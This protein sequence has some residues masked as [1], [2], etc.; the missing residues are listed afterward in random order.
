M[1]RIK[2]FLLEQL[3]KRENILF[4]FISLEFLFFRGKNG[5]EEFILAFE[6][7]KNMGVSI[8]FFLEIK[9]ALKRSTKFSSPIQP[10]MIV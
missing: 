7:E 9:S 3:A 2:Q 6:I 10:N 4:F 1:T 8:S 5:I